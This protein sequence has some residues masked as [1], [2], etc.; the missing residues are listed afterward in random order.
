MA[1]S[2]LHENFLDLF[3]G[4]CSMVHIFEFVIW[5][6]CEWETIVTFMAP[7]GL[8]TEQS[9]VTAITGAA[10][11]PR[12]WYSLCFPYANLHSCFHSDRFGWHIC[13]KFLL[14][15]HFAQI[16]LS[17]QM[18]TTFTPSK[19]DKHGI[20]IS[21]RPSLIVPFYEE[22][23]LALNMCFIILWL[24]FQTMTVVTIQ[25]STVLHIDLW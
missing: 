14:V 20:F 5:P 9:T 3:D 17:L 19:W 15:V 4:I 7:N 10:K 6:L 11:L 21:F 1:H 16:T 8:N 23:M 25:M 2:A 22:M 12:Q 13:W 24:R 18:D